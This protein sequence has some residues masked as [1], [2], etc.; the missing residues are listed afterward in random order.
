MVIEYRNYLLKNDRDFAREIKLRVIQLGPSA[1]SI[2]L[3]KL[4]PSFV[5]EDFGNF[6]IDFNFPET[7]LQL[8]DCC[9]RGS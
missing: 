6:F 9:A 1:F 3:P 7:L 5:I 8:I 4:V 2:A